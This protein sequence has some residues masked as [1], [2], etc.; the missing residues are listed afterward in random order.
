MKRYIVILCVIMLSAAVCHAETAGA[1]PDTLSG[2]NIS[3]LDAIRFEDR[4]VAKDGRTVCLSMNIIL[5]STRI[6]TQHT[7]S[8]TPVMV[9]AD[10]KME[11]PFGTVIVDGRTRHKVFL[12]RDRLDGTQPQRDSALAIIQRK[13]GSGQEY[14]YLSEIPYCSWM[15]D[16]SIRVDECVKGCADCG[17]GESEKMLGEPVLPRFIPQWKTGKIE[18]EPEPVKRR[19]ES[20]I[21][22]LQFRWDRADILPS[23]K[24]NRTVLDTVTRSIALVKE[25]DYI[26]ITGIYVGG[27]ASPE[28][29]WEY[30]QRLSER[31]VGSFI[32]YIAAHNDVGID[33]IK[34]EWYGEDWDGFR[35]E[36]EKSS[37]PKRDKVI[38]I[39]DRYTE[40]RNLCERKM[41]QVL[42]RREY[43]WLLHNIYPYLRHCTYRV[44]Y[45][46]KNFDLGEARRMIYDRP[47]DLNLNEMY[48]VAGSYEKGTPEYAHAM[49][50]AARHY[51]HSPAVLNDLA[52]EAL[53]S[54]NAAGAVRILEEAGER[55]DAAVRTDAEL[56]NTLGVAYANDGQYDNAR[57]VLEKSAALGNANAEHNLTQLLNVIDQL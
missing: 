10:R 33:L 55:P 9:S 41:M 29:T 39:I 45:M 5:D 11:Q 31:R 52:T 22:R 48:K 40:D 56:L 16:G 6:R 15:L 2:R 57:A 37:F 32:K 7:V 46:V 26:E 53:A 27:Y 54:G 44:E 34:G 23:W 12:R 42:S 14:A 19:E 49:A 24:D 8:L 30:N 21:A 47:Q 35:S 13:N 43:V 51:P 4:T 36:L 28:G 1:A 20:R 17:E 25:K 3:Y 50:M 18:P 38:E